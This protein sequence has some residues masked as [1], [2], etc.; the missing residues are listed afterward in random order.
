MGKFEDEYKKL[1]A[2]QKQAVDYIDGPVLVV[3]GPGTGKTQLLSMRTANILKRTDAAAQNILCLTFTNKAALNM[4]ERLLALTDNNARDV[5]IKTFHSFA[6][7]VMNL[8]PD[9]FWNGA[10]LST[11]PDAVQNETIQ[12]ILSSLPL[13][14]PLALKFAGQFT[15]GNDVRTA[16]RLAKEAGLT[17]HKLQALIEANLAYIDVI[18]PVIATI[19]S[20]PLSFKRL[21]EIRQQISEL[22]EQGIDT[23]LAPLTSLTSVIQASLDFAIQQDTNLGK[24][25]NTGKWKQNLVQSRDGEKGMYKERERNNWWLSLANV[26]GLYRTELHKR[27]H[28]D[29]SD[30][31][32]EVISVLEQNESV[33]SD[34]QER[35]QYVLIDEFQDS[36]A[37]QMRLAHLVADHESNFGKPN[38]MAVGD[39]DQSIYKFNGAELANML[40][41]QKSYPDTKLIVLTENYR[42]SQNVLDTAA[43]VIEQA[44][45]RLTLRDPLIEKQLR[46]KNPP[47]KSG[48]LIHKLYVN[49]AFQLNDVASEIARQYAEGNHSIAVLAR[50]NDSLRR[51]AANLLSQD[52]PLAYQEQNNILDHQIVTTV[53]HISALASAIKQGDTERVH[54]F[55]SQTLRHPMWGIEPYDLW[56]LASHNRN[57]S[58]LAAMKDAAPEHKFYAIQEWLLWLANQTV[59]EPLLVIIEYI[60]GLRPSQH[61]TSPLRTWYTDKTSITTDYTHGLSALRLLLSLVNEFS[62][63]SAGTLEDFVTFIEVSAETGQIIADESSFITGSNT[64]ELL[65][66][67]KAKG[68]E[69][70]TVYIID[71]TDGNWRPRPTSRRSPANLPLQP[72][73]DDMDDY[74][75]LLYVAMTRAKRTV[76]ATSYQYDEK[77]QEVLTTPLLDNVLREQHIKNNNK[78]HKIEVIEQSLTWPTLSIDKEKLVLRPRLENFQLSATALLD[79]LDVTQG[80][81]NNFK[82][83]HI[84]CLPFAQTTHMA[85]GT[86]MHS[87]LELAQIL[88]NRD[89]L[90]IKAVLRRY[91]HSLNEQNLPQNEYA[92]FLNHGRDLL[93]KLLES[94]SF[95]LP[96]NS[97]PEQSIRDVTIENVRLYGKL[98]RVDIHEQE[99]AIIDYKTGKPLGS[100]F[101]KDQTKAV[102]AWRHRMQLTFYCL[103]AQNSS[104]FNSYKQYTGKLIYLEASS[105][106]ELIR[107]F[108]PSSQELEHLTKLATT[109]W[110]KIINL[111]FPDTST[112][113]Q[114]EKG[115]IEFENDLLQ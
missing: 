56:Q 61:L 5:M 58:W 98:D 103:L 21:E 73:F 31:I 86:A 75:R 35:F 111:D 114:T 38:L 78:A 62:Q 23:S 76:I 20:K 108:S 14:D 63:L 91:Q 53:Y 85:F 6:A 69:F 26:Y 40:T 24:T 81:P 2:R 39:D 29:Y 47:E 15:A 66:I 17:P 45:D 4:K 54:Y 99:L 82:E 51:I 19:L 34:I 32:V 30:M 70:D 90:D 41:F 95:W 27:G 80:G 11:A 72:A 64:V 67:H 115:I 79:F 100:L 50:N 60:T 65:T 92:R 105:P 13:D 1:N 43:K 94:D 110:Q 77:G 59:T 36:N 10:R 25:T 97:L 87:A 42:S 106:K 107:E 68:L 93:Q 74:V 48:Q 22:P 37:A 18:E 44:S 16:L 109:V 52:I 57:K 104:R 89:N 83:R 55:L 28:Y 7:E 49:Q 84:L 12:S 33:R 9:H 88:V 112:Y 71:A 8:Y 113:P 102:K 96:K 46:A 3:A 101:T